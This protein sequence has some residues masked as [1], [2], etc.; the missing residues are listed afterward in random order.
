[1]NTKKIKMQLLILIINLSNIMKM[2]LMIKFPYIRKVKEIEINIKIIQFI[3]LLD[4]IL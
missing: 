4:N 3:K 2:I 1:M